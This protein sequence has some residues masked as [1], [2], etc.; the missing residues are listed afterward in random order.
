MF[1]KN[2]DVFLVEKHCWI[3]VFGLV[4][5][6]INY[7]QST[8]QE[9]KRTIKCFNDLNKPKKLESSNAFQRGRHLRSFQTRTRSQLIWRVV[10]CINILAISVLIATPEKPNTISLLGKEKYHYTS[11]TIVKNTSALC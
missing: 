11:R 5:S 6:L 3:L 1:G 9:Q 10:S 8:E 4:R 2:E 7:Y